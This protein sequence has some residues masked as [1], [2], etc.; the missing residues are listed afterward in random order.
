MFT[1][2]KDKQNIRLNTII[3]DQSNR[4]L[5][6]PEFFSLFKVLEKPEKYSLTIWGII[7][8]TDYL[9]SVTSRWVEWGVIT[10]TNYL[11]SVVSRWVEWGIITKTNYLIST[12]SI[13]VD[14]DSC[15]LWEQWQIC[16]CVWINGDMG[17]YIWHSNYKK[18]Q[19]LRCSQ[20]SPDDVH[21]WLHSKGL[22]IPRV[23]KVQ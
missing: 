5:S 9:I 21:C 16:K 15:L 11:I 22:N 7:T 6:S 17:T 1:T 23:V 18:K 2:R 12:A 14:R 3:D 13:W 19:F 10:Q 8:K 4:S 20:M